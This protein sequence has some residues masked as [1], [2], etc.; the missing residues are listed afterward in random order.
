[1]K[2]LSGINASTIDE[3][4]ENRPYIS[5]KD[6]LKK[7]NDLKKPQIITLI[8]SGA[9][10]NFDYDEIKNTRQAAMVYYI[11]Q[12]YDKKSKLTLQN[13]NGLIEHNL[14]PNKFKQEQNVFVLNKIFKKLSY[15]KN[16]DYYWLNGEQSVLLEKICRADDLENINGIIC[17]KKTTWDKFYKTSMDK[18]RTWLKENQEKIL[19]EYNWTLFQEMWNKYAEGN[20]S[21][22][23]MD[24][25]CFYYHDHELKN[26]NNRKYGII[27]FN[28]LSRKSA[29]ERVWRNIPIYKLSRIAGT[30]IAKNDA[31]HSISL[32]TTTGV[33]NVKFSKD[34]YARLNRQ[35]SEMGEDGHKHIRE[36]GWLTRGTKLLITGYRTEDT[37]RSKIYHSQGG[38]Q[39]YLINKVYENGNIDLKH[40]RYGEDNESI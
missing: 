37:F 14:V 34:Y 15:C 7:C 6:F 3:I 24:A 17:I 16:K 33:V 31:R 19:K 23:E 30:V 32:L 12:I 25:V 8:K 21:K 2:A 9:F 1:M 28:S 18:I 39:V 27:D 36:K 4:I 29:V 22:W 35:I 26:I 10:D 20:I 40:N 38:H 11:S 13:F 5:L